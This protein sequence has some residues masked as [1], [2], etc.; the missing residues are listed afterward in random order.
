M[1]SEHALTSLSA[2]EI[3]SFIVQKLKAALPG[4]P[5]EQH[6]KEPFRFT[7]SHPDSGPLVLN[8]GDLV[9]EVRGASPST[10]ERLVDSF[11]ILAQRAVAPPEL[12]LD[13]VY[14][15]LRHR[16]FLGTSRQPLRDAFV[17]EGPGD[18]LS[19]VLSDQSDG[20]AMV[21]EAMV[22]RAGH[23]HES[24]FLAA[25]RNFVE[26]LPNAYGEFIEDSGV[27]AMGFRNYPWLGTSLM[28]VPSLISNVM[29]QQGWTQVLLAT[30]TRKTLD[31]VDAAAPNAPQV[32]ERWMRESPPGARTQSE[33]V[34]TYD[35]NATEYRKTHLMVGAELLRLN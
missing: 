17:G 1:Y 30:P 24:V 4:L 12:M 14:P 2:E 3:S 28:F 8:I 16:T 29:I 22:E 20:V 35:R 21:N 34:F 15:G 6:V 13:K 27:L 31:L 10:A 25:E 23:D 9:Q 32:M 7:L 19:V 33:V 26:L 11:V 18:L 5:L